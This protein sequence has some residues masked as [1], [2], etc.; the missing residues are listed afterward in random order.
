MPIPGPERIDSHIS[1]DGGTHKRK[2][3]SDLEVEGRQHKHQTIQEIE[4]ATGSLDGSLPAG[5]FLNTNGSQSIPAT[6]NL[7][8]HFCPISFDLA[9]D[10]QAT[11]DEAFIKLSWTLETQYVGTRNDRANKSKSSNPTFQT[12]R[13]PRYV[14]SSLRTV[15]AK[16][17]RYVVEAF[18]GVS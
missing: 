2:A 11:E 12:A 9:V 3:V 18:L 6:N 13:A 8:L 14:A 4:D 15:K 1:P 16:R 10:G 17:K 5:P 7:D